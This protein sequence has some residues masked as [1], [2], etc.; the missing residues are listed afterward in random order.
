MIE[1]DHPSQASFGN[2]A[3]HILQS[4]CRIVMLH[5]CRQRSFTEHTARMRDLCILAATEH[6]F[7]SLHLPGFLGSTLGK[8]VCPFEVMLDSIMRNA[9]LP[10]VR[11]TNSYT[12]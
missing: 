3:V 1:G 10:C 5:P 12:V 11:M 4:R 2:G 9:R 7:P 8:V 6:T